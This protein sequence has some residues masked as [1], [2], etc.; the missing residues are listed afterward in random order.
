M[1]LSRFSPLFFDAASHAD[2]TAIYF[3]TISLPLLPAC[4][5]SCFLLF[6]ATFIFIR[7]S[8]IIFFHIS[9]IIHP[10]TPV[11]HFHPTNGVAQHGTHIQCHGRMS[12]RHYRLGFQLTP[13]AFAAAV[14]RLLICRCRLPF[15]LPL[16]PL[17]FATPPPGDIDVVQ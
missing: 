9:F 16:M 5:L 6:F 1:S 7:S 17:V 2:A 12:L 11:D 15:R 8:D 13:F 4:L 3:S 14:R 10:V